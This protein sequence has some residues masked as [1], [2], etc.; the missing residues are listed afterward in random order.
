MTPA[1]LAFS[2]LDDTLFQTQAKCPPD[3]D[4]A[5]A[6]HH[7]VAARQSYTTGP[8][9]QLIDV[10]QA[11][12]GCLIPVT[13]RTPAAVARVQ[14][15]FA[16][17]VICDHGATVLE[18][19]GQVSA[20][21]AARIQTLLADGAVLR[22]QAALGALAAQHECTLSTHEVDRAAYMHVLKHPQRGDLRAAY[23]AVRALGL[24]GLTVIAN[25]SHISLLHAG[26]TKAAAVAFVRARY[27]AH[28][29]TLGLGDSLSDLPF[30][31]TC[32]F[33]LTPTGT[34]LDRAFDP[35]GA[36]L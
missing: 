21:W 7:T 6:A 4:L 14:L 11:A 35:D 3:A 22:V 13:G 12:G 20:E 33:W 30:M 32:Q 29:L 17:E 15:L 5:L 16:A 25:P 18:P 8:Q 36:H 28:L 27:P 2:D 23:H 24:P 1:F 10:L 34:Q 26:V 9:R 19:D 31:R